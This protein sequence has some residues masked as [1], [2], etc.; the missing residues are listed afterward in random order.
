MDDEIKK[1]K[2][3]NEQVYAELEPAEPNPTP[4]VEDIEDTTDIESEIDSQDEVDEEIEDEADDSEQD[5]P[6]TRKKD[7]SARGRISDLT[8]ERDRERQARLEAEQRL[9]ALTGN[10]GDFGLEL[11]TLP[12][13][14]PGEEVTPE[15]YQAHVAQTAQAITRIEIERERNNNRIR[16]EI[17]DAINEY[18]ELDPKKSDSFDKDLSD[19]ITSSVEVFLKANPT[20]SVKEYIDKM[21]KPYRR[22]VEKAVGRRSEAV[23]KQASQA[24]LRPSQPVKGQKKFEDLSLEEMEKRLGKVY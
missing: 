8:H 3:L 11:P 2:T 16:N 15:Q 19:T 23:A 17:T 24:A 22:S 14:K 4:S 10:N 20:G 1:G 6:E 12:Q 13:L 7:R 5:E 21:M 18:Q 9:Q